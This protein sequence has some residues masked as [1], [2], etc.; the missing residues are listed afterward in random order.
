[1]ASKTLVALLLVLL[2]I[3]AM[4][5]LRDPILNAAKAIIGIAEQN[6]PAGTC[7]LGND[8]T[9]QYIPPGEKLEYSNKIETPLEPIFT[10]SGGNIEVIQAPAGIPHSARKAGSNIDTIVLHHTAGSTAQGAI[11]WWKS[12]QKASAHYV[13]DKDGTIYQTVDEKYKA[14]HAGCCIDKTSGCSPCINPEAATYNDRSI[15][16]EIVNTGCEKYTAEQYASLSALIESIRLRHP[17][18]LEDNNNII[19]HFQITKGKWDVS[20]AFDWSKIDLP[21]HLTTSCQ[22]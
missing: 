2:L 14:W 17:A 12:S 5:L 20:S 7:G 8:C 13:I 11:D 6:N 10:P 1:M 21:N 16:I 9:P 18:I 15:G 22:A 19:G 4:L 3:G